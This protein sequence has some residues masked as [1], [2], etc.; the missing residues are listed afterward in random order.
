M[1]WLKSSRSAIHA[2]GGAATNVKAAT[3]LTFI[4][5]EMRNWAKCATGEHT[6]CLQ[7]EPA[8][9]VT[10]IGNR[11]Y[12][13]DTIGIHFQATF[14]GGPFISPSG[15]ILKNNMISTTTDNKGDPTYASFQ[16]SDGCRDCV[17]ENNSSTQSF[18]LN[19]TSSPVNDFTGT[20]IKGNVAPNDNGSSVRSPKRYLWL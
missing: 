13:C 9:N 15:I 2:G 12:N 10:M 3:G 1:P 16:F 4:G 7:F 11:I 8:F 17:I 5:V 14:Q 18:I 19:H 6:E 20:V